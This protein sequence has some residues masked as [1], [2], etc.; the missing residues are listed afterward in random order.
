MSLWL[1]AFTAG[2]LATLNPC[3]FALLPAVLGRF[4]TQ[5]RGG[6]RA[7][8]GLGLLLTL[9]TLSVFGAIGLVFSWLGSALGRYLPYLNL[10]L[11]LGLLAMG[12]L[13]LI[14]KGGGLNLPLRAPRGQGL[15]QFYGFGLAYGLASLGCTLPVF[16]SV[17]GFALTQGPVAGALALL[18][19]GLG[20]GMVLITVSLLVG[21][22]QEG[23]L[24]RLR[25]GGGYLEV[26]GALLLLL[27]GGYLAGYQVALISQVPSG[28]RWAGIGL[29]LLA[30]AAG[31]GLRRQIL[32]RTSDA[33]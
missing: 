19:Y 18:A 25:Q 29:G 10:L 6:V 4:L 11:G 8:L 22:G 21:L 13:T 26:L 12:V 15:G 33:H 24:K 16:L 30:F 17:A 3:G 23:A 32:S 31:Y 9:G 14:G 28:A 2:A 27:A 5:G 1:Y 20:M 7:G